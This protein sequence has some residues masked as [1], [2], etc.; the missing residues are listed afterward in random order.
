MTILQ[1]DGTKL[2][3]RSAGSTDSA[4]TIHGSLQARKLGPSLAGKFKFSDIFSSD[5]QRAFKTAEAVRRAQRHKYGSAVEDVRV[6]QMSILREQDFGYYEGKKSLG[7]PKEG[8]KLDR[9][10]ERDVQI[11]PGFKAAETKAEMAVRMN[12]FLDDHLLP[13]LQSSRPFEP[14]VA[15]VSHGMILSTLWKCLLKR[16]ALHSVNLAFGV[17][18]RSEGDTG[19]EHLGAWSNTGFLELDIK[20][21]AS[22]LKAA[23]ITEIL[24]AEVHEQEELTDSTQVPAVLYDWSITVRAVNSKDHLKGLKR[25]GGGVGSSK[26]DETQKSIDTFFKKRK[27]A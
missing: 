14:L 16:F 7:R 13:L 12:R 4:L 22:R 2:T 6:C 19:F 9:R 18:I 23:E 24:A 3:L 8:S 26:F 21:H 17:N 11:E 25:T 10:R 20:K 15:I 1:L 5:L 27:T